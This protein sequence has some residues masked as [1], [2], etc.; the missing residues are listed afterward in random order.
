MVEKNVIFFSVY[1]YTEFKFADKDTF[2]K[3][4][5]LNLFYCFYFLTSRIL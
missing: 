5:F 1:N 4:V 3:D 2:N